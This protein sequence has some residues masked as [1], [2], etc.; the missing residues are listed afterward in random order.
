MGR[1]PTKHLN[2]P[3]SVRARLQRS[4]KTYY[5][6]VADSKTRKEIALGS[7]YFEAL[8][9]Y[10]SLMKTQLITN[11]NQPTLS[12]AIKSYFLS[13][14]YFD[15]AQTT[16]ADYKVCQVKVLEFFNDP[17]AKLESIDPFHIEQFKEWRGKESK[18]R[19]NYE[20]AF[21]SLV[22][23][24]ARRKGLTSKTNPCQGVRP[25]KLK[26]RDVN[27]SDK[28][29]SAIYDEACQPVRDAMDIAYL[30]GQRPI[31]VFAMDETDIKKLLLMVDQSKTGEKV[32]IRVIGDLKAV[33][34]RIIERKKKCSVYSLAIICNER[35]TRI[36]QKAVAQRFRKIRAAV[37]KTHPDLDASL[38]SFQF[39]DLRAKSATEIY[40]QRGI[41]EAQE[42]LGHT[43]SKMT[44]DYIRTKLGKIVNPTK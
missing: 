5:Y 36:T 1:K 21:I 6:L 37:I 12:D 26:A 15:L 2:L 20:R 44:E 7:D 23:N 22:W 14:D 19:A 4:G 41:V 28:I 11:I 38:S 8:K 39:R 13:T 33:I 42:L 27:V 10:S 29:Y 16:K 18:R 32:R 25:F 3:K 9:K 24:H 31:D 43:T 34:D 35:G 40:E 17:P 30:T